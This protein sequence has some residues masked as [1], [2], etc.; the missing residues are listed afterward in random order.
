[1]KHI[2]GVL[3]LVVAATIAFAA[4]AV[5]SEDEFVRTMQT[6]YAFLTGQ[7]LRSAIPTGEPQ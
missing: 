1:L 6:S 2:V 3:L 4:P 7:Q 5:A